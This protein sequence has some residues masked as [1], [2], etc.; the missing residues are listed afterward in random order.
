MRPTIALPQFTSV[1]L[2]LIF[3][4]VVIHLRNKPEQ[5]PPHLALSQF[6]IEISG[7]QTVRDIEVSDDVLTSLGPGQFLLRDYRVEGKMPTN[8][9]I[10]Y[11]SQARDDEIHSPKNCL[12]GAGWTAIRSGRIQI[13]RVNGTSVEVNRFIVGKGRER[14][15][16][17]YWYQGHGRVTASEFW[18]KYYL[19]RDAISRN[20]SDSALV[21]IIQ[22]YAGGDGE[23]AAEGQAVAFAKQLFPILDSYIPI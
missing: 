15:V 4:S 21:R 10:F 1:V 17:L 22:P 3:A 7:W 20:R 5:L 8:L 2:L 19:A 12:P 16:V 14:V 6:P 18:A 23:A 9:F 13:H 11:P